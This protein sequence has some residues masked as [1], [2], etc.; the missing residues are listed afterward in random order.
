MD[1]DLKVPIQ[2]QTSHDALL[3]QSVT[4]GTCEEAA[5][6]KTGQVGA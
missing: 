5:E 6:L 1:N 4:Q 2:D 3:R